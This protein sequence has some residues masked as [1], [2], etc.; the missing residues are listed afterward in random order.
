[1]PLSEP[2]TL[3]PDVVPEAAHESLEHLPKKALRQLALRPAAG[4]SAGHVGRSAAAPSYAGAAL[5]NNT[6]LAIREP[7]R[8]AARTGITVG[9]NHRPPLDERC[10]RS[11]ETDSA[12]RLTTG[13]YVSTNHDAAI[14]S[15]IACTEGSEMMTDTLGWMMG[16]AGL[17]WLLVVVALVLAIGAL[18]KYLKK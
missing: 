10:S 6:N 17:I 16:G 11:S 3:Q 2:Q 4:G 14:Q 5:I 18:I 12:S 8:S 7:N 9:G 13:A 1:M 15:T